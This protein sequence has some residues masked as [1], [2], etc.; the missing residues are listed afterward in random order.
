VTGRRMRIALSVAN[1]GYHYAAWRLPE[2]PADG[3]HDL[4]HYIDCA[5]IAERGKLDFLFLADVAAVRNL[6][7]PRIR[8]DMEQS[9]LKHE[10]TLLCAAL[11]AV[12]ERVGLVPTVS[13]SFHHPY[14]VA[15]RLAS[16]D[17]ISNGRMGWNMVTSTSPDEAR[18]F[19]QD[20]PLD[21]TTRH[22]RR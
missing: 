16:I 7:D 22:A 3:D 13:T 15:R 8:R 20:K 1:L 4:N 11:A 6:D 18:N 10:P 5:R 19:G 14:N 21:S 17:H 9:H 12:T 2:V